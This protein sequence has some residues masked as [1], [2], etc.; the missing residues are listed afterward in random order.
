MP[1]CLGAIS[2]RKQ[3]GLPEK[4]NIVPSYAL[5]EQQSLPL[6][7]DTVPTPIAFIALRL[8]TAAQQLQ[9]QAAIAQCLV[10]LHRSGLGG[11]FVEVGRFNLQPH[12]IFGG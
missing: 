3:G 5:A 9:Q 4:R 8:L 1:T 2:A 11:I 10:N 7:P 12:Q 6:S